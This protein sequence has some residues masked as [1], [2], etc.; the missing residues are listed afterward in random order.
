[1]ARLLEK[2]RRRVG[3]AG[4]V[5]DAGLAWMER[6]T[7][8]SA[9]MNIPVAREIAK[10]SQPLYVGVRA[11][12]AN[13]TSGGGKYY[14]PEVRDERYFSKDALRAIGKSIAM[15]GGRGT[16][17]T[18]FDSSRTGD[19]ATNWEAM[20]AL[21]GSTVRNGKVTDKFDVD[22]KDPYGTDN[23]L[24]RAGSHVISKIFGSGDD[25]DAGKVRTE[26]PL[27]KIPG[28]QSASKGGD[29]LGNFLATDNVPETLFGFP[30]VTKDYTPE[31]LAFFKAH[32]EAGGFYSDSR[33]VINPTTFSNRKDALCVAF[34]E[35]FRIIMEANGFD[36]V[37]EP[38]EKQRKFFSDTE[39]AKDE[40]MMRRTI[41][42][43]ICTFDT[44]IDDATDEQLQEALEFL[45][46]V[47]EAGFCKT[48][49]EQWAV[50]RI[51]ELIS[52]ATKN[53]R[54]QT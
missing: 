9:D 50:G 5:A 20:Q 47:L 25:P 43:R 27:D 34:D 2:F 24:H 39:Y 33:I 14:Q 19:V 8:K 40:N 30:I 7:A 42:A 45:D 52:A 13:L 37:A 49:W 35:G 48:Q 21:G 36:P 53:E 38:T 18:D 26:I 28:V 16:K 46:A 23:A 3:D 12:V 32:P 15:N 17:R 11:A 29:V 44:S 51:R 54:K 4:M 22:V 10:F 1:M 31:D 41:L 6:M